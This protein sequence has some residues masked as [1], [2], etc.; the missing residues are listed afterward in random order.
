[1]NKAE[2]TVKE[3][4]EGHNL[5]AIFNNMVNNLVHSRERQPLV[6]MVRFPLS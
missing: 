2:R 6:F 3:Y 5:P 1:M 4:L